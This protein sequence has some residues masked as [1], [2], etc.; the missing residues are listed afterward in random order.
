[1]K[2]PKL[3]GGFAFGKVKVYAHRLLTGQAIPIF[4][5]NK[6]NQAINNHV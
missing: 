6:I 5:D 3:P 4:R 2:T 1:M